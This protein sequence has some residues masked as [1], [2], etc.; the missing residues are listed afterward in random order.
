MALTKANNPYKNFVIYSKCSNLQTRLLTLPGFATHSEALLDSSDPVACIRKLLCSGL[1]L[2]YLFN[3]LPSRIYPRIELDI[4]PSGDDD[5]TKRLAIAQFA[6]RSN[7]AF[8]CDHFTISDILS[9]TELTGGFNKALDAVSVVLDQLALTATTIQGLAKPLNTHN[10]SEIRYENNESF[11]RSFQRTVKNMLTSE[12]GH[13]AKMEILE[14]FS[15]VLAMAGIVDPESISLIFPKK[16]F[17]FARKFRIQLECIAQFPWKEQNWGVPF[18]SHAMDITMNLRIH[19]VNWILV[20]PALVDF[21]MESLQSVNSLLAA[22][23]ERLSDYIGFLKELILLSTL[24]IR[25]HRYHD[26]LLLGVACIQQVIDTV[27]KAKKKTMSDQI[28]EALKTRIMDWQDLT[29]NSLGQFILEDRILTRR[30]DLLQIF[31]VFLFENELLLCDKTLPPPPPNSSRIGRRKVSS[32]SIPPSRNDALYIKD[33]IPIC[34]ITS[35]TR[36]E[37]RRVQDNGPQLFFELALFIESHVVSLLHP[38]HDGMQ[39]WYHELQGLQGKGEWGDIQGPSSPAILIRRKRAVTHDGALADIQ[40]GF[41]PENSHL[42]NHR[43]TFVKLHFGGNSFVLSIPLPV[44]YGDLLER[45]DKKL[46][47][48][49]GW[50][51]DGRIIIHTNADGY[52]V[53]VGPRTPLGTIFREG[54]M[55]SLRVE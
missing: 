54:V 51:M 47:Y 23:L 46:R 36:S 25:K 4:S 33:H 35:V 45:I 48:S 52:V 2:C 34:V 18:I 55:A 30:N 26:E 7:Q 40:N 22:P 14:S 1:P 44:E 8:Q 24:T 11:Q 42:S 49:P 20:K 16:M 6:L 31:D 9:S 50:T 15:S 37:F 5:Y 39:K 41:L 29:V 27:A 21:D 19:C 38:D 43:S 53:S 12:R 32:A 10:D 13:V 17:V 28:C 3:L